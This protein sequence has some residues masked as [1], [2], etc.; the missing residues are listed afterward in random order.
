MQLRRA[1]RL[2]LLFQIFFLTR[3]RV[4]RNGAGDA[5]FAVAMRACGRLLNWVISVTQVDTKASTTPLGNAGNPRKSFLTRQR[6]YETIADFI[7]FFF[8]KHIWPPQQFTLCG[9]ACCIS[10]GNVQIARV[11]N[12]NKNI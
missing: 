5:A 10:T 3:Q 9:K 1:A 6:F 2:K 11:T 7:A 8:A 12:K 4:H